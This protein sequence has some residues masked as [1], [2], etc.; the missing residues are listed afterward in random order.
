MQNQ[1]TTS[2]SPNPLT[3]AR[4][5]REV[6]WQVFV[7]LLT[8]VLLVGALAVGIIV[9]GVGDASRWAD[10][11]LIWLLVPMLVL[12]L[13]P[14]ALLVAL[15]YG[16]A[17]LMGVLPPYARQAQQVFETIEAVVRRNADRAVEPFLRVHAALGALG[18]LRRRTSQ[19]LDVEKES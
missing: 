7:P 6:L 17:L 14:L 8:G 13:I 2:P 11:S 19:L 10:I 16:L 4:H 5:R 12:A 3:R 1:R 18:A 9:S 15:I